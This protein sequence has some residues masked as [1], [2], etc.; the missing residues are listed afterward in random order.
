MHRVC[1]RAPRID[2][3]SMLYLFRDSEPWF[4]ACREMFENEEEFL[5]KGIEVMLE[6][7]RMDPTRVALFE[8]DEEDEEDLEFLMHLDA[9]GGCA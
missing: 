3:S 7:S 6:L 8:G 1:L 4:V 9:R 5:T 2:T